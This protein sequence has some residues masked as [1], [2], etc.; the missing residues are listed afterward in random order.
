M[1][2]SQELSR[3]TWKMI[4]KNLIVLAVLAVVAFIGVMS[5]FTQNTTAKADGI[6]AK[7]QVDDGLEF[8]IMP[9]SDA[10]QYA[11]INTRLADNVTYNSEH[12][13]AQRRTTWHTSTDGNVS[14]NTD[15]QEFMF[16]K[17]LFLCEVTSDGATFKVPKLMQY[18]N[19][20]YIDTTQSFDNA[21]PND[22]YLSY[23]VYFRCKTDH[24]GY[25][26]SLK[27][28]SSIS[29]NTDYVKNATNSPISDPAAASNTTP[30][31]KDAA[32]GAVRMS[33]L[34]LQS[35]SSREVLWIPGPYVYY[36]GM[37]NTDTLYTGL[38]GSEYENKG[39]AY[40]NGSGI[41]LRTGEG[42]NDHAYY[43][44]KDSRKV[45]SHNDDN[46]FVGETLGSDQEVVILNNEDSTNG[47][48]YGRIRVNLWIE[49]ED[50][51]ARLAFV[52]G[53][54]SFSM[55]YELDNT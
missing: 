48:Y 37:P 8:Y 2:K 39:A 5:W 11:A 13:E 30:G 35:G 16:M 27:S 9:P 55:N 31:I 38:T 12:P 28:D 40:Y 20:A 29:P 3:K 52:G 54:F 49:G 32:I 45:I 36:N 26:V 51:E 15:D 1:K 41:A 33:V 17:D 24:S 53:K 34:N 19:V 4:A 18:D 7:T 42:T 43:E 21:K 23:D 25:T 6:N 22:E 44:S 14:F 47:Y 50:A 10:D 46:V